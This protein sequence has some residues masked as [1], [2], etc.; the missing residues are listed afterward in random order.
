MLFKVPYRSND[1]HVN[2]VDLTL[3][4]FEVCNWMEPIGN[5]EDQVQRICRRF[6]V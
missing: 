1:Q 2:V 6:W 5:D 4:G 3:K